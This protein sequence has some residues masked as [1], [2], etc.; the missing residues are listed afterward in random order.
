MV[1]LR[2]K[3][4]PPPGFAEVDALPDRL[5]ARIPSR[6]IVEPKRTILGRFTGDWQK[7]ERASA[8][9]VNGRAA[10]VL[11]YLASVPSLD[12]DDRPAKHKYSVAVIDL[13]GV[14]QHVRLQKRGAFAKLAGRVVSPGIEVGDEEFD[15]TFTVWGEQSV[16][17]P[18][19]SP[20]A[21]AALMASPL[22]ATWDIGAGWF[23]V[24][25]DGY[26][27]HGQLVTQASH[28]LG[29]LPL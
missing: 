18:L 28:V 20:A 24:F 29:A 17:M 9:Q 2:P 14:H 19:L 3:F 7:V 22:R 10:W 16:A 21:R 4:D 11:D 6:E 8:G 13:T 26:E 15:R 27:N 1:G 23:V 12:S 5:L 25:T